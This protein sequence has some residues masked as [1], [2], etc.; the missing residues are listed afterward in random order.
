MRRLLIL[1]LLLPIPV[2]GATY[3]FSDCVGAGHGTDNGCW[4]NQ[5]IGSC[6]SPGSESNPYCPDVDNNGTVEFIEYLMDGSG[7]EVA[8]NDTIYLCAGACDSSSSSG[9]VTMGM[10]ITPFVDGPITITRFPT[11]TG[12]HGISGGGVIDI[13]INN[14]GLD[15]TDYTW[16]DL[17]IEKYQDVSVGN[18]CG[19][20]GS[21]DGRC[22]K[23]I[24][25]QGGN[26]GWVIDNVEFRYLGLVQTD[27]G[28]GDAS[29][30]GE[31]SGDSTLN[32]AYGIYIDSRPAGSTVEIKNS[33][34]HHICKFA[35]R[36]VNNENGGDSLTVTDTEFYNLDA[37]NNPFNTD[38][39]T[40]TR[41]TAYDTDGWFAEKN[42]NNMT[43]QDSTIECRGTYDITT[44][45]AGCKQC[46]L[47]DT[48]GTEGADNITVRRNTCFGGNAEEGFDDTLQAGIGMRTNCSPISNC[49]ITNSTI[50][51]NIIYQT[52]HHFTGQAV[53]RSGLSFRSG[54][55]GN[56]IQNNTVYKSTYPITVEGAAHTI[57]NNLSYDSNT[58]L[59]GNNYAELYLFTSAQSSTVTNNNF[60][61]DANDVVV[62]QS[63][64]NYTCAGI[65]SFGTDNICET[66]VFVNVAGG[67]ETWDLHLDG[68]DTNN[69]D[70]GSCSVGATD[71]IDEDSRASTCDIGADERVASA[72]GS[73]DGGALTGGSI[74]SLDDL[75]IWSCEMHERYGV[76]ACIQR[77]K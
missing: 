16:K 77:A 44:G 12:E 40:Y 25:L 36:T 50:E 48:T 17:V 46:V 32:D 27:I 73:L 35:I 26:D 14:A 13:A 2:F 74:A 76:G 58:N 19:G 52:A 51:N 67:P 54:G 8:A 22:S 42:T 30:G 31:C 57:R 53:T 70:A 43:L 1:L 37:I 56:A 75:M 5:T 45:N 71:D 33:S 28:I 63:S 24:N 23:F 10:S 15:R 6:T 47:V 62:Q 4:D 39:E 20:T 72:P 3:H 29:F 65:G 49:P 41:I 59:G 11:E 55:A 66:T 34:F 18:N 9:I 64:T 68:T 38:N 69:I 61:D 21:P 7:D 60:Y